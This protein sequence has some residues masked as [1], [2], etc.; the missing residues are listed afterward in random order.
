MVYVVDV[1]IEGA[2][3]LVRCEVVGNPGEQRPVAG[4][5]LGAV[6][7]EVVTG[8]S[9]GKIVGM[10]RQ[11]SAAVYED[12][13]R[14]EALHALLDAENLETATWTLQSDEGRVGNGGHDH[15]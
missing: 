8:T 3:T 4:L 14:A 13:L 11:L 2:R 15:T 9:L 1:H 12:G 6:T 5:V 10:I 7:V